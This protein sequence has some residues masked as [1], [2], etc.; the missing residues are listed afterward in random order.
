MT[1]DVHEREIVGVIGPNG[2]GKTT[3]FDLVSGFIPVDA[4]RIVLAGHDITSASP[5]AR[6]AAGLGRSFQ[7]ALLFPEMTVLETLEVATERWVGN[8]SAVAAAMRLP[9]VFDD[10]ER[11]DNGPRS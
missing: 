2:A 11:T 3:M 7:D 4:G 1:F 10:E 5:S 6:A 8:R 9:M